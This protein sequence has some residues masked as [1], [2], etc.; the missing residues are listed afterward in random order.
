[1][2]LYTTNLPCQICFEGNVIAAQSKFTANLLS[3]P[4]SVIFLSGVEVGGVYKAQGS[5]QKHGLTPC[6]KHYILR[7]RSVSVFNQQYNHYL[8]LTKYFELLKHNR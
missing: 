5:D 3:A 8:V 4:E 1:M 2:C 6:I 7:C